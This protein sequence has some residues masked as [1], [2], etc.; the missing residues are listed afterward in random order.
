MAL[1][2]GEVFRSREKHGKKG[3]C[4]KVRRNRRGTFHSRNAQK[5][6]GCDGGWGEQEEGLTVEGFS[7]QHKEF[8]Y[9]PTSYY[10][11]E[12]ERVIFFSQKQLLFL[13]I[14]IYYYH[15]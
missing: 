10:M 2:V 6:S 9:H 1:G 3:E 4:T 11:Q 14:Y 5:L 12:D 15:I 7:R 8:P 13:F